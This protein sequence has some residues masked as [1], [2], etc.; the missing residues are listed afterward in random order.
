MERSATHPYTIYEVI[1][2]FFKRTR[3]VIYALIQL[4]MFVIALV[5]MP[6][7]HKFELLANI[8]EKCIKKK[9]V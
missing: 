7:H 6:V 4:I 8:K 9:A 5:K 2:I 3:K 1:D